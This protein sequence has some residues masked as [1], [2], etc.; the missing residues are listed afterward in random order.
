MILHA[1]WTALFNL[2]TSVNESGNQNIPGFTGVMD[3]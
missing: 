3:F 1:S 2:L